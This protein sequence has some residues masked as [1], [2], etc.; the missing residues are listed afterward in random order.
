MAKVREVQALLSGKFPKGVSLEQVLEAGCEAYLER[1]SR[2]RRAARRVARNEKRQKNTKPLDS[3]GSH[4][5]QALADE[6]Y[7]RDQGCCT[8]VGQDGRRCGST[9]QVQFEHLIPR[10][11][12]GK[13]TLDNITLHC[14]RH[15]RLKA[16]QVFGKEFMQRCVQAKQEQLT[17]SGG[18]GERLHT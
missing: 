10:A 13:H 7:V 12:G 5:P 3:E 18:G 4:I 8:F 17:F 1:N 2:K 6:V 14:A 16:D 9:W 15:N 11:I